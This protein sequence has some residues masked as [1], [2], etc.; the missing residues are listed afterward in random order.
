MPADNRALKQLADKAAGTVADRFEACARRFDLITDRART[1]F[2]QRDWHGMLADMGE[3]LELHSLEVDR[4]IT[5]LRGTL[6]EQILDEEL[7]VHLKDAYARLVSSW[8]N[9]EL[10][11]T[12]FNSVSRR[13][14]STA[15]INPATEFDAD[16][17]SIGPDAKDP[18]IYEGHACAGDI[19]GAVRHILEGCGFTTPFE[20]LERSARTVA[21]AIDAQ[22]AATP[23]AG[24]IEALEMIRPIFFR[25]KLAYL[26]GRIRAQGAILPLIL[27]LRHDERGI[28][29]DA[30]LMTQTELSILFSFTRSHFHV[31]VECPRDLVV[32]LKKLMPQKPV[33]ELYIS[34]GFHKHGKTELYR[35]LRHC[36]R[37]TTDRFEF[38]RG[39]TGMV[40]LVFTL[41]G[42]E[43]VFK[44]IRDRFAY[45]KRNTRRDVMER[46]HMVFVHDRVGRL[47]EAQE[48]EHLELSVDRFREEVLKEL[49]AQAA[50]TVAVHDGVVTLKHVYVERKVT[51][52]NLYLREVDDRDALEVVHDY[53]EAV[54]ELAAANIF[55]GDLL[56]KNF[57]VTRHGR[58]VFYD[59]DELCLLTECNFRS[60]PAARQPED[61]LAAEP[62]FEVGENDIFP[63]EFSRFLSMSRPLQ[64]EFK[65]R[66]SELFDPGFWSDIQER[67]RAGEIMDV[68]PYPRT[69]RLLD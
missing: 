61:E 3:R 4:L 31:A 57:G 58:V 32:F 42:Y 54:K 6:G 40:M 1:R 19:I 52:L 30:V 26:I 28:G 9:R 37:T 17:S 38:A 34:L 10:A 41:P 18:T 7:W 12:F 51:P 44:V 11:E 14:L 45:P 25:Q 62:W 22:V 2:E 8:R 65:R 36:L 49:L 67:L 68:Y 16:E 64:E 29:L 60:I 39:D 46:Y 27:V 23:G 48:F 50:S 24:R 56:E 66:H 43:Y 55:P 33:A 13:V 15:G 53:G 63:E 47:V 69:K 5:W 59:Y 21:D 20:D 35:H